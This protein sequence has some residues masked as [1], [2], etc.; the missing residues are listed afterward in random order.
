MELTSNSDMF[1]T[2]FDFPLGNATV[3]TPAS[4][5]VYVR[6]GSYA[7]F[8]ASNVGWTLHDTITAL[9][10]GTSVYTPGVLNNQILLSTGQTTSVYLHSITSGNGLRYQGTGTTSTSTFS[11]ADLTLFSD[12]ARTGNVAFGGSQFAPRA[13]SGTVH[14]EAVPEPATMAILGLGAAALMRRRKK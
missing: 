3:G 6:S 7:G 5:E 14:Y 1:V 11:N 13:F 2:Q 4:V 8:T 12:V 9:A 10:A